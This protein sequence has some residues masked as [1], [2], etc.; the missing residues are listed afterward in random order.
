MWGGPDDLVEMLRTTPVVL[1]TLVRGVDNARAR[2]APG[3]GDWSVVE[4]AAHLVDADEKAIERITRMTAENAPV[5][6]GYDQVELAER[7][8]YRQMNL[9]EVLDRFARLRAERVALLAPLDAAGW[10]RS[11]HHT[12]E[13]AITLYQLTL[14]MCRH[15]ATHLTQIARTLEQ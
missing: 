2:V 9:S 14:H 15:D 12:Q 1:R 5:I 3:E 6:E 7:H 10:E 11:G 8:G 4:V 13:G